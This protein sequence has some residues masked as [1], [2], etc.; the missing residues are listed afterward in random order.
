MNIIKFHL[1]REMELLDLPVELISQYALKL[2]LGEIFHLCRVNKKFNQE[3]CSNEHFC[4]SR[5]PPE[6][7][8]DSGR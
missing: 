3:I 1:S 4:G 8:R 7:L 5:A 2:N 6:S